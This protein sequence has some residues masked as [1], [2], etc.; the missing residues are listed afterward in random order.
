MGWG[1]GGRGEVGGGGGAGVWEGEEEKRRQK[2]RQASVSEKRRDK[3]TFSTD[4]EANEQTR[5]SPT[6][7]THDVHVHI[8]HNNFPL[9]SNLRSPT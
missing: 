5:Q 7:Q 1:W 3:K 6:N 8:P 4:P 9:I 2:T